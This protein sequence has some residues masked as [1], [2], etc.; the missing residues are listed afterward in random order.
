MIFI[1]ETMYN[2]ELYKLLQ[3]RTPLTASLYSSNMSSSL[4]W[5]LPDGYRLGERSLRS[6]PWSTRQL[7]WSDAM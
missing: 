7:F 3:Y 5:L 4:R 1:C 2:E 6:H